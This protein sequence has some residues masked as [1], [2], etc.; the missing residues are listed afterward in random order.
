MKLIDKEGTDKRQPSE[1]N[2]IFVKTLEKICKNLD[3][4]DVTNLEK[5]NEYSQIICKKMFENN[6]KINNNEMTEF[7][8]KIISSKNIEIKL[9]KNLTMSKY[10]A[11]IIEIANA[12]SNYCQ[13]ISKL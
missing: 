13:L 11:K 2:N 7:F 9:P 4:S 8:I 6:I 1:I 5:L 3:V 12:E 10:N